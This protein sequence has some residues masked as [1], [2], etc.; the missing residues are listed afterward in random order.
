MPADCSA[1]DLQVRITIQVQIVIPLAMGI[2]ALVSKQWV[3]GIILVAMAALAA[4]T[5]YL[6]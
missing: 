1:Y 5:F 2:A 4:L 6:W 3:G